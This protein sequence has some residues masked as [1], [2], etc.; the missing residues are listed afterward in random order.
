M[1]DVEFYQ[2]RRVKEINSDDTNNKSNALSCS[3]RDVVGKNNRVFLLGNAGIG[4]STELKILCKDLNTEIVSLRSFPAGLTIKKFLPKSISLKKKLNQVI[5]FDGLDEV[6]N[7][8]DT[9]SHIEIF[10]RDYKE[11]KVVISCRTNIYEKYGVNL[12]GFK[13]FILEPLSDREK[14]DLIK[15][16]IGVELKYPQY[17]SYQNFLGTPFAINQFCDFYTSQGVF[18]KTQEELWNLFI[19]QELETL[20][21]S[22]LQKREKDLDVFHIK[23]CLQE[24]AIINELMS[25]NFIEGINLYTL[26]GKE[27]KAILEQISFIEHIPNSKR[28]GFRHKIYQEFFAAQYLKSF[29]FNKILELIVLDDTVQRT[30]PSLFNVISFLLNILDTDKFNKLKGWLLLNEPDILLL[31]EED[32]L[33]KNTQKEVFE[34]YFNNE[35]I[36]TTFWIQRNNRFPLERLAKFADID[37]LINIVKKDS[38]HRITMSA[39][40]VLCCVPNSATN[41]EITT[42]FYD[43]IIGNSKY[44]EHCFEAYIYNNFDL[45]NNDQFHSLLDYLTTSNNLAIQHCII[46]A[47]SKDINQKRYFGFLLTALDKLY[48][49][50]EEKQEDNVVRMTTH[51]VAEI[52][53]DISD[54]ESF[55]ELI[56][57]LNNTE[58]SLKLSDV[59]KEKFVNRFNEKVISIL[60]TDKIYLERFIHIIMTALKLNGNDF[61]NYAIKI[62]V[63]CDNNFSIVQRIICNYGI[64]VENSVVLCELVDDNV[65]EYLLKEYNGGILRDVGEKE[66]RYLRN[67]L[68]QKNNQIGYIFEREFIE[69]G[70]SF[71]DLLE[72]EQDR[73]RENKR[74]IDDFNVLFDIN[75]V[76]NLILKVFKDNNVDTLS[77]ALILDIES[78]W[79]KENPFFS[80]RNSIYEILYMKFYLQF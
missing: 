76:K 58:Y 10:L 32:R 12:E 14:L 4:K 61:I 24:V 27:D 54:I 20:S 36:N 50:Y 42:L 71:I 7:I 21:K 64:T 74:T 23:E 38:N 52:I 49:E 44:Q 39:F 48:L 46:K 34:K 37:Y 30:K 19:E 60:Y 40:D 57:I 9:L 26:L 55:F 11:V 41:K 70:F 75:A 28:F 56:Q 63:N 77:R 5:V 3:L 17:K 59:Y 29:D 25:S 33:D 43:S 51:Y 6:A 1:T 62:L 67:R 78:D 15:C 69:A 66:L 22:H 18:P 35:V 16:K 31:C 53:I 2:P 65:L 8:Y 73:L 80:Y 68:F 45:F 72:T 79:L 13:I 47:L